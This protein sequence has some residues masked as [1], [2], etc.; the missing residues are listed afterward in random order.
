METAVNV[1]WMV[2]CANLI[3]A[4][5]ITEKGAFLEEMPP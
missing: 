2:L 3:Q 1:Y 4:G 5:V